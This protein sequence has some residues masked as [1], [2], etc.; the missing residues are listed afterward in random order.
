MADNVERI[1]S[2]LEA[3]GLS[4]ELTD[5]PKGRVV[6]FDYEVNVGSYRG[7]T[8]RVGLSMQGKEPYPEYPPHWIHVSPPIDDGRG[9]VIEQYTDNRGER[10]AVLSRP[11]GRLWDRLLTKHINGYITDHLRQFWNE[12]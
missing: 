4:T 9:G 8:V 3:L 2:E 1:N 6:S 5:S 7:T 12:Q 10:W 11:P